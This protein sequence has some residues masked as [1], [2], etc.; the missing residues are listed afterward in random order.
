MNAVGRDAFNGVLRAQFTPAEGKVATLADLRA[1]LNEAGGERI[2]LLAA[3]VF[4]QPTDTDLLVGLPQP[5]AGGWAS[6]L[7]NTGSFDV[8]VT[9]QGMTEAG[10]R[11][12]TTARVPAKDFGEAQF[13]TA[14]RIVR[15]EVD[16]DKLYPQLDYSNDVVPAAPGPEEAVEQAR[17]LITQNAS[18]A[19]TLAREVLAR[20][21]GRG[22]ARVVL[23][24]ALL[25]QQKLDEAEREFRAALD[26]PLPTPSAL[27]WSHVGLGEIALRRNRAAEAAK[28]FDV[29]VKTDAEYA[30]TLAA[31][32]ARLR[33]EAAAGAAPAPDE[34]IKAAAQRLDAAILTGRKTEI[35]ANILPGEL[36]RFSKGLI[37]Q[38]PDVWQTR[39]LRTEE[40]EPGRVAADVSLTVRTL[41]RD[42]A[43]T[44]V[45]VFARTTAGWKLSDIQFFEV[46]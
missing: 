41:G 42:Q 24:R 43:G 26:A 7:R 30:S 18:R 16:P 22:E 9:V 46:R 19:E 40:L 13:K 23:A 31:R 38:V 10:E 28:L 1:R 37:G 6:N 14:A 27:A 45:L 8:E 35:D 21:P 17:I 20:F 34:Q 3:A 25:E 4:D 11:V 2:A 32:A 36:T 15:V 39:V 44:A 5:K 12:L 29:A 33:A